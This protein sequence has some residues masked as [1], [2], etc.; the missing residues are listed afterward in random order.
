M[1][2]AGGGEDIRDLPL[3]LNARQSM[4]RPSCSVAGPASVCAMRRWPAL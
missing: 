1:F 4:S 3:Y 2:L